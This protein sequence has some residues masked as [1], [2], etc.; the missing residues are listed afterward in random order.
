MTAKIIA[1]ETPKSSVPF[2][3]SRGPDNLEEGVMMRSP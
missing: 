1:V 2:A 3:V